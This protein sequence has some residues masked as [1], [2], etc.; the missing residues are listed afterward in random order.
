[1]VKILNKLQS[2]LAFIPVPGN[3]SYFYNFGSILLTCLTIQIVTGLIL[4]MHYSPGVNNSFESVELIMKD[5]SGGWLTRMIHAN[6]ASFFFISIY[7]HVARGLFFGSFMNLGVWMTGCFMMILFMMTAFL[8][9]VLPWGQMSYW[10]ATVITNLIS[11]IP[12][13]GEKG[14]QWL[15]GGFSVSSPTLSRFF[16]LHFMIP[17]ITVGFVMGHLSF[18]HHTQSSNPLGLSPKANSVC[19]HPYFSIKDVLGLILFTMMLS[20]LVISHPYIFMDSDNFMIANPMSTP[21][22]IQPEWYFLFAY[23]ILRA[24][25]SKLG[26]VVALIS[27]IGILFT[28][29]AMSS[30]LG[31]KL[32]RFK[33]T[34]KVVFTILVTDF[35][36]LTW[37]GCQP[38]EP[39]FVS[40]SQFA[41]WTYFIS[42]LLLCI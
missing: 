33:F 40:L 32:S 19:F 35:I 3:I 36:F 10:G 31:S 4:S 41:T 22:H 30:G 8:G 7:I 42:I 12:F 27:S 1:M 15:W 14:V 25:P 9:Y 37:L 17:L 20:W 11:V 18:L 23:S 16:T 34:R 39:P 2:N 26:G 5:V 6:G 28:L 13:L 24:I 38:V 21:P 29:P